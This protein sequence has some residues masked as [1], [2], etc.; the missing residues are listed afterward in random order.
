[1]RDDE[2]TMIINES[3]QIMNPDDSHTHSFDVENDF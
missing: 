1:M 3:D 2:V